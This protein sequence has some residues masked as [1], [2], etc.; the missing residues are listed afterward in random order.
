MSCF[1]SDP[2]NQE[3]SA[4]ENLFPECRVSWEKDK[5]FIPSSLK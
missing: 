1:G 4:G 2:S 3:E 5:S